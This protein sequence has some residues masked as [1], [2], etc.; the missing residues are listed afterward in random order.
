[1]RFVIFQKNPVLFFPTHVFRSGCSL[2]L[3][4]PEK[5][6]ITGT[7]VRIWKEMVVASL[8]AAIYPR[9]SST[10]GTMKGFSM[11]SRTGAPVGTL[12]QPIHI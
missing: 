4:N 8:K 7:Y 12:Y 9:H 11:D 3:Q 5:V 1:M 2:N 6:I 10:D